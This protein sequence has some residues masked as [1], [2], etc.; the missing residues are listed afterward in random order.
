MGKGQGF[1][2][3]SRQYKDLKHVFK[4]LRDD[5][6]YTRVCQLQLDP[7]DISISERLNIFMTF[8]KFLLANGST[9]ITSTSA[10]TSNKN[11]NCVLN[12][13][14]QTAILNI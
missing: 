14:L 12:G 11:L 6:Y 8:S 4:G 13:V 2:S 5:L 10:V 1:L 7:S 9:E 3:C